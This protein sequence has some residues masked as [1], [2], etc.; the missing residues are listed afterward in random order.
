MPLEPPMSNPPRPSGSVNA[1]RS[2]VV[3]AAPRGIHDTAHREQMT[4]RSKS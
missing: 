4:V 3:N 2:N 1:H